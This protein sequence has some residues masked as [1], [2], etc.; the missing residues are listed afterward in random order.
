MQPKDVLIEGSKVIEQFLEP[1][2]FRFQLREE[3]SGSGGPFAWG[4]FVREDRRLELHFRYSLGMVKYQIGDQSA[5]HEAYMRE[6]RAWQDCRYPGF[7]QEPIVAFHDLAHDLQFASD[8]TE[9]TGEVL[10]RASERE[11]AESKHP[12]VAKLP[13]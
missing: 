4:E 12:R 9:G 5:S 3:G 11:A 2:G 7:S 1:H 8:F 10:I 6:L 13:D